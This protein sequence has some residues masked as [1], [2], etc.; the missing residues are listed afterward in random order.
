MRNLLKEKNGL[1]AVVFLIVAALLFVYLNSVFTIGDTDASRQIFEDFYNQEEE[2][3]DVM[4][5]GTSATNRYYITPKAYNDE[6]IAAYN[7]AVMGMPMMFMPQLID[8]VEKTQDPQLYVVELRNTLKSKNEVTDAHIRRVTDSMKFSSNKFDAINTAME[9][10]EGATGELS[11]IDEGLLD[12]YVPIIK[13]HGRLL[14]GDMTL[15]DVTMVSGQTPVQGFVLS[16]K[17]LVVKPQKDSV[18]SDERAPLAPEMAAALESTLDSFDALGKEVV[19]VLA[20]YSIK[21]GDAAKLNTAKDMVE[22]RGYKVLDFNDPAIF[23][24][25]GINRATDFYNS[26]HVNYLGAEKYTDYLTAYLKAN[27]DIPDRRGD[28]KYH[29]WVKGYEKYCDYVKDGIPE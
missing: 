23:A 19:F 5:M 27:Y 6:G 24:A 29:L 17:T 10:T 21:D 12:Y 15:S 4:Y 25:T 18:L 8:E 13:Y 14:S 2:S 3:I 9:Y 11:N 22:A 26:K 28:D 7:L 16:P 1:R 20:P